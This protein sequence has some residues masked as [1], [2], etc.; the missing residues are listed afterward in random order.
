MGIYIDRQT[1]M[2]TSDTQEQSTGFVAPY[3][4]VR[5]SLVDLGSSVVLRQQTA[6]A[7]Q[8]RSTA[9]GKKGFNPRDA[10]T[11]D[12]KMNVLREMLE[13]EIARVVPELVGRP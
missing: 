12:E 3:V 7:S 1:E 6:Y 4:Y 13:K 9:R 5:L 10:F 11:A 2:I 8:M